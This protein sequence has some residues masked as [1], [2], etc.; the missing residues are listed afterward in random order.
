[1]VHESRSLRRG[2]VGDL[3]SSTPR[4]GIG[5]PQPERSAIHARAARVTYY[6]TGIWRRKNST[7]P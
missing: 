3:L 6:V 2:Q 4:S 5:A 7:T 1:M